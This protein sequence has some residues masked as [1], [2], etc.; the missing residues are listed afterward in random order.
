MKRLIYLGY[1]AFTLQINLQ[2]FS[3]AG[4]EFTGLQTKAI[5]NVKGVA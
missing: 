3:L 4:P 5:S 1:L 2:R